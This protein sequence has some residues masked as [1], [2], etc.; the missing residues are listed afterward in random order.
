MPRLLRARRHGVVALLL[1][2]LWTVRAHAAETPPPQPQPKP[3]GLPAPMQPQ[4][5]EDTLE[6]S[7]RLVL[8]TGRYDVTPA[9]KGALNIQFHGEYQLRCRAMTDL[10]LE[11]PTLHPEIATLGQN[12]YVYHWLRFGTR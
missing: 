9:N 5:T 1:S 11:P 8:E 2:S 12:H 10:P 4:A 3:D 7:P 6:Y